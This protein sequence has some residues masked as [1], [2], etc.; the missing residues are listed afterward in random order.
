LRGAFFLG[1]HKSK[2]LSEHLNTIFIKYLLIIGEND[3]GRI[4]TC[5]WY[6]CCEKSF[7]GYLFKLNFHVILA[8]AT[9][10]MAFNYLATS[11]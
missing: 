11:F 1:N 9:M 4:G 5:N 8:G 3:N 2:H 7:K 10:S 6:I